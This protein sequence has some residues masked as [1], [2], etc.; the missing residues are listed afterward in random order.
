MS[1]GIIIYIV[2]LA[3]FAG[4][5]INHLRLWEGVVLSVFW[6]VTAPVA[7]GWLWLMD[8]SR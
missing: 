6:P 4:W 8:R 7:F 3:G 2:G 1:I 5:S